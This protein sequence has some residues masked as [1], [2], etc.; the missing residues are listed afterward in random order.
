[1]LQTEIS[2]IITL[3]SARV[4]LLF[5]KFFIEEITDPGLLKIRCV[6]VVL[7][8]QVFLTSL[9][10]NL[11]LC[12][13]THSMSENENILMGRESVLPHSERK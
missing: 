9:V 13:L 11:L 1:M 4:S 12:S 2:D 3:P 10:F 6:V 7:P 5:L 8:S